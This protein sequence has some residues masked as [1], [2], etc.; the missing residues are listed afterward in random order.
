MI[1][2]HFI[3]LSGAHELRDSSQVF[4]VLW[5][6][7]HVKQK[8]VSICLV[9]GN[10]FLC[11]SKIIVCDYTINWSNWKWIFHTDEHAMHC[12]NRSVAGTICSK[13]LK[14]PRMECG[15]IPSIPSGIFFVAAFTSALAT[16]MYAGHW[17]RCGC[18]INAINNS[19]AKLPAIFET[20]GRVTVHCWSSVRSFC[21]CKIKTIYFF[22]RLLWLSIVHKTNDA[23]QWSVES[24]DTSYVTP[25]PNIHFILWI[26][27]ARQTFAYGTTKFGTVS[28]MYFV[29]DLFISFRFSSF[30]SFSFR[31]LFHFSFAALQS[32]ANALLA[33]VNC[34]W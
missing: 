2:A 34:L 3:L 1:T 27:N 31:H 29:F 28:V 32:A 16:E 6:F 24:R 25:K 22:F 19:T 9:L 8:L 26:V 17:S 11:R 20:A 30:H 15:T 18:W 12:P 10:D 7:K 21:D 5:R 13:L 33:I 4:Q 14:W 23:K